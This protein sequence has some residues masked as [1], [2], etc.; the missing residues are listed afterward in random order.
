M[1]TREQWKAARLFLPY[2][3]KVIQDLY[4]RDL[5]DATAYKKTQKYMEDLQGARERGVGL[6]FVGEP[7]TGKTL[8]AHYVLNA[9]LDIEAVIGVRAITMVGFQNIL[10]RQ[11]QLM[12]LVRAVKDQDAQVEWWKKDKILSD[13]RTKSF[14]LLDDVGKE[15]T[16][17]TRFAEDE[18]DR[19]LR[20]RGNKGLPTIMTTNT[21]IKDWD[22]AYGPSLASYIH[23][24]CEIIYVD[25][26][27][28]RQVGSHSER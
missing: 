28:Y 21:Q 11:M 13:L 6:I 7:G 2:H 24:V 23:Q 8:L 5:A 27:D 22:A 1:A 18:F 3:E 26:V 20:E 17:A 4:D 15:H 12:D 16:T 19:L 9:L 25:G 10:L 14:V